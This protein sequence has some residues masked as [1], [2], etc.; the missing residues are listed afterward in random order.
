M[1]QGKAF[2][3]DS[4]LILYICTTCDEHGVLVPRS[5]AEIIEIAWILLDA[6]TLQERARDS[7]LVRPV[8]TPIT[9]L[10][11]TFTPRRS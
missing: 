3:E 1:S 6:S 7:V 4:L 5:R 8:D 10:C 9:A 11:S 2:A